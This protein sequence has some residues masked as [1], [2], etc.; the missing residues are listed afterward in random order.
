MILLG[1]ATKRVGKTGDY[2]REWGLWTKLESWTCM[3]KGS[4]EKGR[5]KAHGT[6]E[7]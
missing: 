6:L 1:K 5:E 7:S 3:E 4:K 2:S